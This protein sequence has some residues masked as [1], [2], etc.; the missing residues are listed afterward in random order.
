MQSWVACARLQLSSLWV[1]VHAQAHT[2]QEQSKL[3]VKT[4][5]G[6]TGHKKDVLAVEL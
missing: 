4:Q 6:R 2:C 1:Q 3:R 5:R